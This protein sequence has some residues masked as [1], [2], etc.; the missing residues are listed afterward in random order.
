MRWLGH[1]ARNDGCINSITV[2]EVDGNCGRGRPR[3][4][5]RD[6]INHDLKNWR[7][8]RIDPA[9]RIEWR[10]KLRTNM[11]AMRP[12]LSGTGMLSE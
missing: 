6:M 12:T 10:K 7:L 11:G 2:L 8:T 3:K 5:W 9:N 1:V 4:A